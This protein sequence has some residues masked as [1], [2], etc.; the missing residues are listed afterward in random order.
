MRSHCSG[1]TGPTRCEQISSPRPG[2]ATDP[3]NPRIEL[4]PAP[5]VEPTLT[6][7]FAGAVDI[8]QVDRDY[9]VVRGRELR[10]GSINI[11]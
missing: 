2:S 8:E 3:I 7:S 6:A 9:S 5:G 10:H 11:P 4:D 1:S